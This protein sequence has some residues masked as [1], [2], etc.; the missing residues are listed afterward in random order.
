[1]AV[2]T[3]TCA[4]TGVP[5]PV[6]DQDQAYYGKIGVPLP[7]LSPD[8]RQLRR[9]SFRN[10]RNLYHRKCDLCGK[11]IISIY[12]TESSYTVYCNQCWWSDKWDPLSYGVDID[13]SRP[14]F[15]QMHELQK[16]I[17]RL[18]L[19]QKNNVNSDYTNHTENNKNCYLCVDIAK[20]EDVFHSKWLINCK[21]CSD[22]YNIESSELCYGVQYEVKGYRTFFSFFS[23]FSTESAFLYNCQS[24]K[25]CFMCSN[26]NRKEYCIYNKQVTKEEYQQF[27]AT[28]DLG[29]H[30]Q[31]EKYKQEYAE[32]VRATPKRAGL[33]IMSENSEGD[34]LYKCKNVVDSFD[35]IESQDSRYCYEAGHMKD[36]Y[37]VY[38]SAFDCELQYEC[39]GCNRGKYLKFGHVSYDV[40]SSEYV[41]SCHNSGWLLGCVSLRRS[42]Y[43]ILNKQYTKDEFF[44]LREKLINHMRNSG[45]WG[46]FF[47]AFMSPFSYNETIAQEYYPLTSDQAV[48]RG[49]RWK[50][51][52]AY[53]EHQGG[54]IELPDALRDADD[55]VTSG[56]L[57]CE[58]SG[59]H[60][61]I[62]PQELALH[63]QL[64]IALPR[65]APNQRYLDRLMMRNL[66]RLWNWKCTKCARP[67]RA[68]YDPTSTETIYCQTC[69]QELFYS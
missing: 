23:D 55:R 66:R 30:Q 52:D 27:M 56:I 2:I 62:L 5:F 38:E 3:Q 19:H 16:R 57:K 33:I 53:S 42:E 8:E 68:P 6:D 1:M 63:K 60:Y 4:I 58:V 14:F 61:K 45:E 54:V 31:L 13:F 39:H 41:D 40:H 35:V 47:P 44:E 28:V 64:G 37:D 24:C 11:Q 65:R 7:R 10:E 32:M 9:M 46:E 69:F 34:C 29:S 12:H 48:V 43:C 21:D 20:C 49:Y 25:N 15:E 36:C 67:I 22:C 51:E 59:K 50:E 17:P 26:L 18:A